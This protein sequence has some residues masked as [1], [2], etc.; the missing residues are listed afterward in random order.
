[1]NPPIHL[2]LPSATPQES[3]LVEVFIPKQLKPLW[4]QRGLGK[5]S[6]CTILVQRKPLRINTSKSVSKQKTLSTF[7]I[8]TYEKQARWGRGAF[9]PFSNASVVT[10]RK[11]QI[12]SFHIR[13]HSFARAKTQLIC[14]QSIP[15]SLAK[16]TRVGVSVFVE[17]TT[18]EEAS[19]RDL[20]RPYILTSL[21]PYFLT[22]R[23]GG[24]L[25]P[26]MGAAAKRAYRLQE[27][28]SC[29]ALNQL[30]GGGGGGG[31]SGPPLNL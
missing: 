1:L 5:A 29:P 21:P 25:P 24:A 12:L 3:T 7:R 26:A 10:C 23:D 22:S 16:N 15:H 17:R 18:P 27:R 2:R 20:S 8:N 11:T 9:L 31:A 30:S 19:R 13:A 28:R 14:F 6:F 4:N